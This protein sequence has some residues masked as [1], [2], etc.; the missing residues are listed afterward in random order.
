[1]IK[2]IKPL[3]TTFEKLPE[4]L[5]RPMFRMHTHANLENDATIVYKEEDVIVLLGIAYKL[6]RRGVK[7]TKTHGKG[8]NMSSL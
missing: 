3:P 7:K 8:K 5:R 1:M 6:K 4:E 2:R